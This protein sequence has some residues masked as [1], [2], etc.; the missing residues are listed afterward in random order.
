MS[1][2]YCDGFPL[3]QAAT[4]GE[5]D[6]KTPVA[7]LNDPEQAQY[8]ENAALTLGMIGR[9]GAVIALGYLVNLSGSKEALS[10]LLASTSP[11]EWE[12]RHLRG[13]VAPGM[14]AAETTFDLSKYAIIA[15]GLSGNQEAA[16]HL[17][18]LQESNQ[19]NNA[20]RQRVSDV[21]SIVP[22]KT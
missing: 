8:H 19:P 6:V 1:Q 10:Y 17:Q 14:T 18:S 16:R 5:Q 22:D 20:F 7:I 12:Q 11:K 2:L 15:L 4:Y 21:L 13:L 9:V 3:A